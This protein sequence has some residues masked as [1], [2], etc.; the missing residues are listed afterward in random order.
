MKHVK[1]ILISIFI[2]ITGFVLAQTKNQSKKSGKEIIGS[3]TQKTKNS[4]K[5][6]DPEYI[7]INDSTL[8]I[9]KHSGKKIHLKSYEFWELGRKLNTV[10]INSNGIPYAVGFSFDSGIPDEQVYRFINDKWQPF[11][12]HTSEEIECLFTSGNGIV[13]GVSKSKIFRTLENSWEEIFIGNF[14]NYNA[15]TGNDG[16]VYIK[17]QVFKKKR[18]SS[19]S[20]SKVKNGKLDVFL[21]NS[22]PLDKRYDVLLYDFRFTS[23]LTIEINQ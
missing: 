17:D 23:N 12:Q 10:A 9:W 6:Y 22:K 4:S 18:Y 19:S 15:I 3:K 8:E 13:Y 14:K 5:N 7:L 1:F 11:E 2:S 20:L 16:N 21:D